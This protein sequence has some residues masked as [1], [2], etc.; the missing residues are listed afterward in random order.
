MRKSGALDVS[1]E[2]GYNLLSEPERELCS[3][4]KLLPAAYIIIKERILSEF[5]RLGVLDRRHVVELLQIDEIKAGRVF[6]FFMDAGWIV[7][8]GRIGD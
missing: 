6:E 8:R 1:E 4:L 7:T 5:A 2:E 3:S